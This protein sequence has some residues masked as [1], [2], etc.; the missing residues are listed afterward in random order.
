MYTHTKET[1]THS[2]PREYHTFI[3]PREAYTHS[4]PPYVHHRYTHS[5]ETATYTEHN[6]RMPT[7]TSLHI[8]YK[9]RTHRPLSVQKDMNRQAHT[10]ICMTPWDPHE[11]TRHVYILA[12]AQRVKP[13]RVLKPACSRSISGMAQTWK[14]DG[15]GLHTAGSAREADCVGL[16]SLQALGI[17]WTPEQHASDRKGDSPP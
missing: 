11:Q 12:H 10:N 1:F 3:C 5:L 13:Q 2:H 4:H 17:V 6:T 15:A 7:H 14:R 9:E 16:G 8:C